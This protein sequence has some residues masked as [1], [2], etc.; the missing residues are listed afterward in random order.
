MEA[1]NP[2]PLAAAAA[3]TAVP[4]PPGQASL[5][6]Q[7]AIER[8]DPWERFRTVRVASLHVDGWL[9]LWPQRR[10]LIC[11]LW[12][13]IEADVLLVQGA[14]ARRDDD[15]VLELADCL[16]YSHV[17]NAVGERDAQGSESTAVLSRLPLLDAHVEVLPGPVQRLAAGAVVRIGRQSVRVVS[18]HLPDPDEQLVDTLSH[19][20]SM[21]R[22]QDAK[23]LVGLCL[24]CAAL[25]E[26]CRKALQGYIGGSEFSR[27]SWPVQRSQLLALHE[28]ARQG[29]GEALDLTPRRCDLIIQKGINCTRSG[30]IQMVDNEGFAASGH[31]LIWADYSI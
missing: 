24:G 25:D 11:D 31:T 23:Y 15:Q 22:R 2:Q 18:V 3:V 4:S 8:L 17:V 6:S 12:P 1:M 9:G 13:D 29:A 21:G 10:D 28:S 5:A 20:L 14:C 30:M 19:V 27:M 26:R 16:G 7:P